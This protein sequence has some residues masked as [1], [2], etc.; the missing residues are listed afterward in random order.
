LF[1]NGQLIRVVGKGDKVSGS[2]KFH[3][4]PFV[5]INDKGQVAISGG[6]SNGESAI[7]IATPK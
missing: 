5:Q 4:I 2:T 7:V 1:K 6:L 3:F